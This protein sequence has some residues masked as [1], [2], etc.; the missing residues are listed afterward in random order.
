MSNSVF[1]RDVVESDL[2]IFFEQQ[3]DW[4]ANQMAAFTAREPSNRD[5][6]ST[7]WSKLLRDDTI[8]KQT[9]LFN[10]QVAGHVLSFEHMGQRQVGYWLGQEYW[11]KRIA[12]R[13][14]AAFLEQVKIRP[15][16][17]QVAKDNVG[18]RRVLEKCGFRICGEDKGFSNARWMEVE[19]FLLTL[20]G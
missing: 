9:I 13:A 1:L 7:H 5:A 8:L 17:A 10:G 12:T 14:L 16:Y 4:S 20:E 2:S 19:E 11:G 18:S 6:F 15:L 3:L